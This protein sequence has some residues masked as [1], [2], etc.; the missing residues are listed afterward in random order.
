MKIV[1]HS[2]YKILQSSFLILLFY[3]F[4][5]VQQFAQV[6]ESTFQHFSIEDGLS[7]NAVNCIVQDNEGFIWMGT[8]DGLNKFNG[9]T[10]KVF[11][12]SQID[13]LLNG[14]SHV[15][16]AFKD[17]R[18]RLWF[19]S[20]GLILYHPNE[21]KFNVFQHSASANSINHNDVFCITE[22]E[23]HTIWVGTRL[24]LARF[25]ESTKTFTRFK[26]DTL[27]P[28]LEVYGKNRIIEIIADHR[29]FLWLSTLIGLHKFSILNY[30]YTSFLADT[31]DRESIN[32]NHFGPMAMTPKGEIWINFYGQKLLRFDTSTQLFS[33][34]KLPNKELSSGLKY[35]ECMRTDSKG[36]VW[37]AS[38]S[39][40]L[41]VFNNELE[42]WDQ[43]VHDAFNDKSLADNKTLSLFEDRSGMMWAGTASRGVDR[44][45]TKPEKFKSYL[46]QPGKL[47]SLCE[48]DI[49]CAREDSKGNLW[50]GSKSGLMYFDRRTNTFK[51]FRH[52]E[53]QSNSLTDNRI[54]A[55]DIDSLDHI[56][57]G[58][59]EGLN[60]YNPETD[61]W[62][63]YK[64]NEKNIDGLPGK[65]VMD[66]FVRSNG[67]IWAATNGMICE[68]KSKSGIF[69]NQFNNSNIAKHKRAF[70][71][72]LFEDSHKTIWLSTT[73][74][75]ILR[76]NDHFEIIPGIKTSKEF[77]PGIVHQF[78]EDSHGNIWMATDQGLYLWNRSNDSINR[79]CNVSDIFCENI[80]SV[81][82]QDDQEI[83]ISTSKGLSHI[84]LNQNFEIEFHRQY[85]VH[86]GLQ[87]NA[88]NSFAG[89][90]LST[91]ELFFGGING[92]N[93]F[94]PSSIR[95]N[96][97]IPEVSISSFKVFDKEFDSSRD[98][99]NSG[100]IEL[101]YQQNFFSF[102][103]SALSFD[104][105]EKNQYAYKLEGFDPETINN[106]TN[107]FASYTNVPPGNYVLH[108]IASN[109]DGKWNWKGKKINI[110]IKPPFWKTIWFRI[111]LLTGAFSFIYYLYSRRVSQI[112]KLADEE[113]NIN[114][115]ISAAQLTAL[116]AQMN[117]HFIFNTLNA[118]QQLIS[119][120]DKVMALNY[121]SKFSK[122]IRLV[123]QNSGNQ[124]NSLADE[125]I[126]L[127]YYL[128]L[129][130]LRF[131][132]KFTYYFSI[133]HRI[134]KES[135]DIPTMLLQPYIENAV[136]HGLLNK[137][138][139]GHLE[140]T[141][142][143]KEHVLMC[144]IED[145]GIGRQAS[146]IINDSK[147]MHHESLGMKVTE[148]RIKMIRKS[149]NTN[150]EVEILDLKDTFGNPSGT[151]V[152]IKIP[153]DQ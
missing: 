57:V 60:Y 68:L 91:G 11:K 37:I 110:V 146:G 153:I 59:N 50:I 90:R 92:F 23:Y 40:G 36:N 115:Q 127:E 19:G 35:I 125:L 43:C 139:Q 4:Y 46:L 9:Y 114:K 21:N 73:R 51:C 8:E 12:I 82:I 116:R 16:C 64:Y 56:W 135:T 94:E 89:I 42:K 45:S 5:Y 14:I 24:G 79:Y 84:V 63:V 132:N 27:G 104:H 101:N 105:P 83:W 149:S 80:L 143:N 76:V 100:T 145:N 103:M 33:D 106:G 65:I 20:K 15:N 130:S 147:S 55:I 119:E 38:S 131:A 124:T 58:T 48:N 99:I 6:S 98:F 118:I 47:N 93:I 28:H 62:S 74:S 107:R 134:N 136:I 95:Q 140:I 152:I 102:E 86:D 122:L 10:T 96:E 13:Q 129:E 18:G 141:L 34:V 32:A 54:Y 22:D 1:K 44:M 121:L 97:Y 17:S 142:E 128:E 123:L 108:I 49:T 67:K 81:I 133:D 3:N 25:D 53:S 150:V 61:K 78:A 87:S 148:E 151:K 111:L 77:N 137:K 39:S 112:R 120:S 2:L 30:K 85:T 75:G 109:N 113:T 72:T 26:L 52:D 31:V 70:Y 41:I 29:G 88:F 138:S 117:P 7:D 69:E 71:C 126:M 66:V 144:T